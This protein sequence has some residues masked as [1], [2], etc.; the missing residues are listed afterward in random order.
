[1]SLHYVHF[2][3]SKKN[4]SKASRTNNTVASWLHHIHTFLYCFP[5]QPQNVPLTNQTIQPVFCVFQCLLYLSDTKKATCFVDKCFIVW[6]S[7]E[8]RQGTCTSPYFV[9][10]PPNEVLFLH[11]CLQLCKE[12]I[13]VSD[14]ENKI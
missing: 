6:N 4:F 7:T 13:V 8:K 3:M 1:M 10:L 11:H 12:C 5:Y 2:I 9:L 14:E